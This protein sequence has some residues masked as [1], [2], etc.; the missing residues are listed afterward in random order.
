MAPTRP[1]EPESLIPPIGVL[2]QAERMF[3]VNWV[4]NLDRSPSGVPLH[5][6]EYV[7]RQGR[8]V[9]LV[10][11]REGEELT[12]PLGYIPGSNWIPRERAMSLRERLDPLTPVIL[13]SRGGERAS[14]L[15]HALERAG[16]RMVA[17]MRGGMIAWRALGF[18]STRDPEL[19][20]QRDALPE[21]APEVVREPGPLTLEEIETHVG[22]PRSTRWVKLAAILLHGRQA[23]V[24]G[25]DDSGVVGTP[26]GDMGELMV[27]LAALERLRGQP[28]SR[29]KLTE[30]LRRRLDTFGRF[31]MHT[32][33]HAANGLIE[34]MRADSRLTAAIGST[35]EALEWRQW[36]SEP[37]IEAR[38]VVLEHLCQPGHVG[39]GHL[40]LMIQNP[41]QYEVRSA[42]VLDLL[43]TFFSIRWAGASELEAVVL[44]G[45]HQ[46]GAVL[47]V[48]VEGQLHAYSWIPLLSPAYA[49]VQM[50]VNH[51][52][53]SDYLR[54]QLAA[55]LA[56]QR[57]LWDGE[58]IDEAALL[59]QMRELAQRQLSATLGH[60]A[61]GLPIYELSFDREGHARVE[62]AGVVGG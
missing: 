10:D 56:E 6:V 8:G 33:I 54:R 11:V 62:A 40:R 4:A 25:R 22:D 12:G 43:R 31:Y 49:G 42:L 44:P 26:G 16:M 58:A 24:D 27:G 55:F 15:A 35:Y 30:L 3:R 2:S 21:P 59:E 52:Q 23:C 9:R 46:E 20:R 18:A 61:R 28:L 37:P 19:R 32:D 57:D 38:P 48:R 1:S 29:G 36:L 53:V 47:D 14:E 60:L 34:S 17:A 7:A 50:F 39:C 45:G 51:P 5:E 13:I 41:E